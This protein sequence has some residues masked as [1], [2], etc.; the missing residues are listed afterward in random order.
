[1]VSVNVKLF[2]QLVL[3]SWMVT[4]RSCLFWQIISF[5]LTPNEYGCVYD[6][7]RFAKWACDRLTEDADF[8]KKNYHFRWSSFWSWRVCKQAILLHLGLRKTACI[9]WEAD[10]HKT[11]LCLVQI[12]FQR[13]NW[14]I[15]LRKWTM[16]G[17]SL[18]GHV[19]RIFVHKNWREGYGQHLISKGRRYVHT[20]DTWS[21]ILTEEFND[22]LC[23]Y[24]ASALQIFEKLFMTMR[25]IVNW[26]ML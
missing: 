26:K 20:A 21:I 2:F 14:A 5:I 13:H 10:P 18:S 22:Q 24:V 15:C 19:E 11:S 4:L 8:D 17:R 16:R 7:I 23:M 9:Y 25:V 1:M 3:I 12:L 6:C